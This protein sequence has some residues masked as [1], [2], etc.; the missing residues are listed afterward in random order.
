MF[1]LV[2]M[3]VMSLVYSNSIIVS[4][5]LKNRSFL[6]SFLQRIFFVFMIV[7]L[8]VILTF[9]VFRHADLHKS[10][11]QSTATVQSSWPVI[12]CWDGGKFNCHLL[13]CSVAE[14]VAVRLLSHWLFVMVKWLCCLIGLWICFRQLNIWVDGKL[15][16]L[17][18]L[19][20]LRCVNATLKCTVGWIIVI[21][22]S[23]KRLCKLV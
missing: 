17:Y 2:S 19:L 11:S 20:V 12:T 15:Q 5:L 10:H 18:V 16:N 1:F 3:L 9:V 7:N 8:Y 4:L 23:C 6:L 13:T 21:L 14:S 22:L